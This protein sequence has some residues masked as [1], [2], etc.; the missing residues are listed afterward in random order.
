MRSILCALA[1]TSMAGA[2]S[3]SPAMV[4]HNTAPTM[5]QQVDWYCGPHCQAH[6]YYQHRRWEHE[7][8]REGYGYGYR[9]HH[10]YPSYGYNYYYR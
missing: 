10:R 7:R 1:L 9:Y 3:A 4:Q 2:A 5:V 6:R 8:W